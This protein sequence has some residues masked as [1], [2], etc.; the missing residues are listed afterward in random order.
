MFTL[1]APIS[2]S[3]PPIAEGAALGGMVHDLSLWGLFLSADPIVK[4]VMIGLALA[5]VW[6]WSIIFSKLMKVRRLQQLA[7]QFEEGFWSAASLDT[8]FDRTGAK[9]KDPFAAVF[10]AAMREWRRSM[11]QGGRLS[12]E[13]GSTLQQRIE[14]VM[15]VTAG[16]E[17]DQIEKHMGFLASVGSTSPFIGLFG[18]VW[19]IMNSFQSIAMSQNTSLTVV[20]PAIAEALFATALGL[21]AAIPAVIAYNKISNDLNRYGNRLDSFSHEFGAIISRQLEEGR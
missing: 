20:A 4:F 2:A 18:T 21:V 9:P 15:E 12:K 1:P 19:G 3:L 17:M 14:R 11:S 8:L 5:S 6:S 13:V 7:D 16:R 10:A